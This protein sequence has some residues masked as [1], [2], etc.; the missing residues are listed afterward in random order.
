[1]KAF[2]ERIRDRLSGAEWYWDNKGKRTHI[3]DM[4]VYTRNRLM[5]LP[6]CSK[7]GGTPFARINRDPIVK[8]D[9]LTSVYEDGDF[10]Q[11]FRPFVVSGPRADDD[12]PVFTPDD[13]TR[14]TPSKGSVV[15][16]GKRLRDEEH[17]ANKRRTKTP[18]DISGKRKM[19]DVT[20]PQVRRREAAH[21]NQELPAVC[22][23]AL[24]KM[25]EA[26]GSK[27]CKVTGQMML[28]GATC[29]VRCR[30]NGT[31]KCL[32]DMNTTH[33][34]NHAYLVIDQN[35]AVNYRCHASECKGKNYQV[36]RLPEDYRQL[37]EQTSQS[38]MCRGAECKRTKYNLDS[39]VPDEPDS[40][41]PM[42]SKGTS[43]P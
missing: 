8:N 37:M 21:Q 6:R 38:M 41:V 16:S 39:I 30:N 42:H 40:T 9:V 19:S 5:R 11:G 7:R 29:V 32:H 17:G 28:K 36:A 43:G 33:T 15:A 1:M 10:D 2:W 26:A 24:Q 22:V 35:G 12:M 23:E 20:E 4:A 31:R 13:D 3:L 14:Q 34:S 25:I 27:G 18:T